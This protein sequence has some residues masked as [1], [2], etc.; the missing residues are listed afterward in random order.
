MCE[1]HNNFAL[2]KI[3]YIKDLLKSI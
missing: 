2:I 1:H 3:A